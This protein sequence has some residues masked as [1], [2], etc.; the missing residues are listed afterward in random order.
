MSRVCPEDLTV[1]EVRSMH[2][3]SLDVCPE[4]AGIFFDEG[5]IA[6]LQTGGAAAL[7]EVEDAATPASFQYVDSPV[8]KRCPGCQGP[9][10]VYRYRY[11]SDIRLDGCERCGGVWV[12]DGE[13]A[14]IAAHLQAP[15]STFGGTPAARRAA[16][17]QNARDVAASRHSRLIDRVVGLFSR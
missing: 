6:T 4:C 1:L 12:Q 10:H 3:L 17:V 15:P 9:M 7:S 11:S 16:E 13:L 14:K 2:G 5:E 8:P